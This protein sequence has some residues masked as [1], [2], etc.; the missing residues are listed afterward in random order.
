MDG[1]PLPT[2]YLTLPSVGSVEWIISFDP[3]YPRHLV[4]DGRM[5]LEDIVQGEKKTSEYLATW[6]CSDE[7]RPK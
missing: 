5:L 7:D 3:P 2:P 1:A 4:R 6:I